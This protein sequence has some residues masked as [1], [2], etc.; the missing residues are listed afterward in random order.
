MLGLKS[1]TGQTEPFIPLL[2][3]PFSGLVARKAQAKLDP[4]GFAASDVTISPG[5]KTVYEN[6]WGLFYNVRGA[7][8][9]ELSYGTPVAAR[10]AYIDLDVARERVGRP[11]T[12]YVEARADSAAFP[13]IWTLHSY[14][15]GRSVGEAKVSRVKAIVSIPAILGEDRAELAA[16]ADEVYEP[17]LGKDGMYWTDLG[18]SSAGSHTPTVVAVRTW[19][20][21]ERLDDEGLLAFFERVS[22]FADLRKMT[23][24]G[25]GPRMELQA[26]MPTDNKRGV[27]GQYWHPLGI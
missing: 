23:H 14:G 26:T 10:T 9:A 7:L 25:H 19:A 20:G 16:L 13:G 22:Q 1:V 4:S 18:S 17:V 21:Q 27:F 5:W 15:D 24:P 11:F 12:H 3:L 6:E 2:G 8:Q